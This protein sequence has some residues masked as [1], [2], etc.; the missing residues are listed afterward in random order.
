MEGE[1]LIPCPKTQGNYYYHSHNSSKEFEVDR[2]LPSTFVSDWGTELLDEIKEHIENLH[3]DEHDEEQLAYNGQNFML[4][5]VDA[6]N[7]HLVFLISWDDKIVTGIAGVSILFYILAC[8]AFVIIT[9]FALLVGHLYKIGVKQG[10]EKY[11]KFVF[12]VRHIA[13]AFLCIATLTMVWVIRNPYVQNELRELWVP[14]FITGIC[15]AAFL[16]H[17]IF[18]AFFIHVM[19]SPIK[20]L[21]RL[22]PFQTANGAYTIVLIAVNLAVSWKLRWSLSGFVVVESLLFAAMQLSFF[23]IHSAG[24]RS[25]S[26]P[27][28]WTDPAKKTT[29]SK[30]GGGTKNASL[31]SVDSVESISETSGDPPRMEMKEKKKKNKGDE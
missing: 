27:W 20:L 12:M 22:A 26:N 2:G 15:A 17:V 16:Y 13:S 19:S 9:I 5:V 14:I 3:E 24:D 23:I 8:Y 1:K 31:S 4:H 29:F 25:T 10:M 30:S 28:T 11:I 7:E 6:S 21:R 18:M